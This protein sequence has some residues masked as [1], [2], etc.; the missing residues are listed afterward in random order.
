MG[1]ELRGMEL[2]RLI[3]APMAGVSTPALAAAVSNAGGLGSIAVGHLDAAGARAQI[4][5]TRRLTERPFGVNVFCHRPAPVDVELER[6]W[7]AHLQPHFAAF[8]AEAPAQLEEIYASFDG[9]GAML[10][11]LVQTRPAVV[12]FHF[13]VPGRG[14][15]RALRAAGCVLLATA[16]SLHEAQRAAQAGV[17]AVVAQG[18]EAGGHRGQFDENAPDACLTT[19]ALT[20]LLVC[21]QELPVI[22]AGG[23]MDG[24]GIGAVVSLGASAAQLGTAYV[25]CP[26]SSAGYKD[27]LSGGDTVMTRSISGRPA[28][29]LRNRFTQMENRP[30][31][32]YPRAYHAGKVLHAAAL[33]RGESG[34]GPHWAG[35]GAALAR[36]LPAG[37]LTRLLL[38]EVNS[39]A[40]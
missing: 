10:E 9:N 30:V 18:Y 35:Q 14:F 34:Y 5:E 4:E 6:A 16:T 29:C 27:R 19:L 22:A 13:G 20:R 11:A 36:H 25:A 31:P 32:A 8:G 3:Q 39:R 38:Q 23:V 24:A 12:S 17:Q 15:V 37:E 33:R 40:Y 2:P 7:L 28:R 1:C 21:R 26:E